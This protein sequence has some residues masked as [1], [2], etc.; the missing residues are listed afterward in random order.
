MTII[1]ISLDYDGCSDLLF[2]EFLNK[3][4]PQAIAALEEEV[5]TVKRKINRNYSIS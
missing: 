1:A 3:R 5:V 4:I 2:E